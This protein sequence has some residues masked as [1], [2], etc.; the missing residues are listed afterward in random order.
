MIIRTRITRVCCGSPRDDE[1]LR[2]RFAAPRRTDHRQR[3]SCRESVDDP[4]IAGTSRTLETSLEEASFDAW[5]KFY[6]PDEN[7]VNNQISYYDKG[8]IVSFVLDIEIRTASKGAKSLDDV[9]RH[10]YDEFFKKNKNYTPEDFQ[11]SAELMAGKPL[12]D[13]FRNMSAAAKRSTSMRSSA[14]SDCD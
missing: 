13:F 7:S 9:F 6:R 5:I 3:I 4:A 14:A 10:L 2:K 12:G 8:D 1:L 11:K